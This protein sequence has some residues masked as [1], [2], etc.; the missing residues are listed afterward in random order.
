MAGLPPIDT[1]FSGQAQ[2]GAN[3]AYK[4]ATQFMDGDFTRDT[5]ALENRL[6][7]QGFTRGTEAF[8]NEMEQLTRGQNAARQSA[9]FQAQGVGHAQ[10]GD[11]LLRAL[12]ARGALGGERERA[13]DRRFN[14]Y[15]TTRGQDLGKYGVDTNAELSRRGLGLNEDNQ[16]FQ[17][18]MALISQSRGGVN[19]PNFG[20]TSP[21]DVGSAYQLAGANA[22]SA[23]NR[24]AADRAGLY[25]LGAAALGSID[26]SSLF[27][28]KPAMAGA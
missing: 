20:G 22:N 17:Q 21:L 16:S 27:K 7:N 9:A 12:Q 6:V 18:L 5:E 19:M 1:D 2:R 28:G 10:S 8:K 14:Q 11:L 26:W 25:G 24:S 23:A 15:S 3:A 4:G 13:A